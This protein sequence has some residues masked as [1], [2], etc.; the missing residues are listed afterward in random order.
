MSDVVKRS[1]LPSKQQDRLIMAYDIA[2][3]LQERGNQFT[4]LF[5][6][7]ILWDDMTLEIKYPPEVEK[8]RKLVVKLGG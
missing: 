7:I 8:L 2:C 1:A 5:N 6:R 3:T 4:L